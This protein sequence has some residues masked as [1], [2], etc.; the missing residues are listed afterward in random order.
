MI[1]H[2][3]LS[4]VLHMNIA[5]ERL[6]LAINVDHLVLS[7]CGQWWLAKNIFEIYPCKVSLA[8]NYVE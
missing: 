4:L 6:R 3:A 7:L 2:N 1:R 5:T 8:M